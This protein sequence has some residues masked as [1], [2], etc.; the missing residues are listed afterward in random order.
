MPADDTNIAANARLMSWGETLALGIAFLVLAAVM[1]YFLVALWPEKGV[2][3]GKEWDDTA[4]LFGVAFRVRFETRLILLVM[5]AGALGSY[6][7]GATSFATFVG[8]RTLL[9]SWVWWYVL[10]TPIGV[11][12]A[13]LFYFAL[14]GGLLSAGSAGEVLSPF[15]VAAVAGLAGLFSKQATDKLRELFDTL[16]RTAPGKGDDERKDKAEKRPPVLRGVEP[17]TIASG[18]GD[19]SLKVTGENFNETSVV[20]VNGNA[21]PTKFINA[22]ELDVH[23]NKGDFAAPGSLQVSVVTPPPGGGT[24]SSL[25]VTVT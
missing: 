18:G 21:R 25:N 7:H 6:V 16:F 2:V 14:R 4:S 23:L 5:V 20:Q 12:L 9:T 15:G 19:V 11:A 13:L 8:N 17:R 24:S 3:G 1:A 10:R 22:T